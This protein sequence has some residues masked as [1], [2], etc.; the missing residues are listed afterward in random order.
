MKSLETITDRKIK[1]LIVDH[2]E[3]MVD[4]F[5]FLLEMTDEFDIK[6]EKDPSSVVSAAHAFE[7]DFV[8][9][10][11]NDE[12]EIVSRR[13]DDT[14]INYLGISDHLLYNI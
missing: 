14:E 3:E 13:E 8:V 12:A 9:R 11:S 5:K 4:T 7:P 6:L 2:G 1:I 10:G